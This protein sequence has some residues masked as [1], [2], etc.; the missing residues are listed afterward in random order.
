MI[1][2]KTINGREVELEILKDNITIQKV[3]AIVNA[4]HSGLTGGGGVDGAIHRAAGHDLLVECMELEF[5]EPGVRCRV[6][7]ACLTN[8]HNLLAPYVI[9]TVAP[10]FIGSVVQGKLKNA[11]EGTDED[12]KACYINCMRLA[13]SNN[14]TSIAFPSLGTGGH[15]YPVEIAA[16]IAVNSVLEAL[17]ESDT[18]N[19]VKFVCYSQFDYDT[20][21]SVL[22]GGLPF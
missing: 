11:K 17:E 9:H 16:P 13:S 8:G 7:E 10:R 5:V 18:I 14:M 19:S 1:I 15:A 6:G 12:L 22:I 2:Q 4:A 21:V 3:D 20:Y